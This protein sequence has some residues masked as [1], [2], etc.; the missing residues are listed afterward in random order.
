VEAFPAIIADLDRLD[1]TNQ[2]SYLDSYFAYAQEASSSLL[3]DV[4]EQY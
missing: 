2:H 4:T 3:R 1:Y